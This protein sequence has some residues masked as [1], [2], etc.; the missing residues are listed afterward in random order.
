MFQALTGFKLKK[1]KK[2]NQHLLQIV[3]GMKINKLF[4]SVL[5]VQLL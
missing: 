2:V 1:K 5:E 4:L 3:R